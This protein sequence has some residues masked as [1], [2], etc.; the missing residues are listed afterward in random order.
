MNR[1]KKSLGKKIWGYGAPVKGNTLLNYM[2]VD[3]SLI[4]KIVEVTKEVSNNVELE[5]LKEENEKLR[6]DLDKITGA[7]TNM[8]KGKLM[9]NSNL[10]SLYDE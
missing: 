10:S 2:K 6:S 9:K 4:E 3:S 1:L 7:L 5:K 8:N